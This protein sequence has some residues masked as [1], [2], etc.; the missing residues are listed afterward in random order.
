M[1]ESELRKLA[2][3]LRELATKVDMPKVASEELDPEKV[4]DFLVFLK[5]AKAL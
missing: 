4:R 2:S 5:M 1:V 3:D